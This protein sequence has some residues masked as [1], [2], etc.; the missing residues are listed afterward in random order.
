MGLLEQRSG[1]G[2]ATVNLLFGHIHSSRTNQPECP[3]T[4]IRAELF[5]DGFR[6]PCLLSRAA[7]T[8]THCEEEPTRMADVPPY[9][10]PP[11]WLWMFEAAVGV[12]A[13]LLVVLIHVGGAPHHRMPSFGGPGAVHENSH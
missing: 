8:F 7:S 9:P 4:H 13:L 6:T 12:M 1:T 5:V 2:D 11:R 10:G 3:V